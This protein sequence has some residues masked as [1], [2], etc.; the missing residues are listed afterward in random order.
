MQ[1]G[2]KKM[3]ITVPWA[4]AG[5]ATP[6]FPTEMGLSR[7]CAK[8]AGEG[9]GR[10]S[11]AQDCIAS[12]AGPRPTHTH[13][14]N[15][16]VSSD[17]KS[18]LELHAN[19]IFHV[20]SELVLLQDVPAQT[21]LPWWSML[22]WQS[23]KTHKEDIRTLLDSRECDADKGAEPQLSQPLKHLDPRP[24]APVVPSPPNI[25]IP[26]T[27]QAAH[28]ADSTK[29][30][31]QGSPPLLL[32]MQQLCEGG[33]GTCALSLSDK[34][35]RRRVCRLEAEEPCTLQSWSLCRVTENLCSPDRKQHIPLGP[36][37]S[38]TGCTGTSHKNWR[39]WT[40]LS[41]AAQIQ[42][43]KIRGLA[44]MRRS[45]DHFC[46]SVTGSLLPAILHGFPDVSQLE[47]NCR[48]PP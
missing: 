46:K 34:E 14:S 20:T 9:D 42:P 41:Q 4:P 3:P 31:L 40:L 37:C 10:S 32:P 44:G 11:P 16:S 39:A 22:S 33:A 36:H 28:T 24:A 29:A 6:T 12:R 21:K 8:R 2:K 17:L 45:Q 35:V 27:K 43:G 26:C 18:R 7:T 47:P 48:E 1:L 30:T 15:G 38:R 25:S 5:V 19:E 23:N 13:C